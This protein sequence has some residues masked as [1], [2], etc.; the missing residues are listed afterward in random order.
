[1]LRKTSANPS[2][3]S[4]ISAAKAVAVKAVDNSIHSEVSAAKELQ[5]SVLLLPKEVQ[6]KDPETAP[7]T[8]PQPKGNTASTWCSCFFPKL[9]PEDDGPP[10][11]APF[12]RPILMAGGG[13]VHHTG[14]G[15]STSA[16]TSHPL[17]AVQEGMCAENVQGWK[18]AATGERNVNKSGKVLFVMR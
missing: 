11:A 12:F 7:A 14:V 9:P 8:D 15:S 10:P 4:E 1:M 2:V 16:Y 18:T 6:E 5:Q 3:H 17:P 13:G